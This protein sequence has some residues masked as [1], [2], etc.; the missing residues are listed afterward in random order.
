MNIHMHM[1]YASTDFFPLRPSVK[2]ADVKPVLRKH[3]ALASYCLGR[4]N[5]SIRKGQ[6]CSSSKPSFLHS[7]AGGRAGGASFPRKAYPKA[8]LI[9]V[10]FLYT[11]LVA[12]NVPGITDTF[13]TANFPFKCGTAQARPGA[14]GVGTRMV[15]L[16]ALPLH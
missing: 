7:S 11:R 8:L 6:N 4:L 1:F 3:S 14:Q 15:F 5:P 9:S 10:E 16:A 2:V 12:N 13:L